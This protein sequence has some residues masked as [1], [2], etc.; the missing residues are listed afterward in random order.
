MDAF[1]ALPCGLIRF[2]DDG[3]IRDVNSTLTAELGYSP[4]E[5]TGVPLDSI[6][7]AGGRIFM[8]THLRPMLQLHGRVDEV[9]FALRGR[10]GAELPVLANAIRRTADGTAVNVVATF[11]IRRRGEFE[12]RLVAARRSAE[13]ALQARAAL[14]A[15]QQTRNAELERMAARL[16]E[17]AARADAEHRETSR[18]TARSLHEGIAQEIAALRLGLDEVRHAAGDGPLQ[19]SVERL[20]RIAAQSLSQVRTLS[21]ELHPPAIDHS[22]L[23]GALRLAARAFEGAHGIP[24]HV[25]CAAATPRTDRETKLVLYRFVEEA[26]GNAARH[27]R[28]SAV[29]VAVDAADGEL[30]VAVQDDGLGATESAIDR[31][32]ALGLLATR[33]RLARIGGA[34]HVT[35]RPGEGFRVVAS[36]RRRAE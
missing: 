31:E 14:L 35:S 36:V 18:A 4:D 7:P 2:G 9:Y 10:D 1:D 23:V 29:E 11:T 28:P 16:R 27:G 24:A 32:G 19:E 25:R 17:L 5:L 6:L 26:L 33:E 20:E 22:D 21:Y 12:E 34:L 8:L 15:L 30:T 3:R 13:E